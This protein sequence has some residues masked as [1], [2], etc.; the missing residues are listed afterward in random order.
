[1]RY[2]GAVQPA[3]RELRMRRLSERKKDTRKMPLELCNHPIPALQ[4]VAWPEK[5]W[6]GS[7]TLPDKKMLTLSDD[8]IYQAIA[9]PQPNYK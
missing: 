2:G 6:Y 5:E 1:M 8:R 7:A 9:I 4:C 3:H